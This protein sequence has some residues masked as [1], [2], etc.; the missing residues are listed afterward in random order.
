MD[1]KKI[2][3][4]ILTLFLL[5]SCW[6]EELEN[7][8]ILVSSE[9]CE[10]SYIIWESDK[11]SLKLKWVIV[12][13]EIKTIVS[14]MAWT[15]DFLDCEAW[16]KVSNDTLISKVSPDFNN[17]NII[18][19]TIQKWS[20]NNQKSN[21]KAVQT[22]TV[23]SFDIQISSLDNQILSLK[24]QIVL[25]ENNAV[26][27]T[28]SSNL[29]KSD[30]EKQITTLQDS[31]VTLKSNLNLAKKG[32]IDALEKIDIT[33]NSLYTN[34]KTLSID[35]LL[36]IDEIF[37]ITYENRDLNDKYDDYLWTKDSI[38]KQE[39]ENEFKTLNLRLSNVNNLSDIEIS[40]FLWELVK[41][42]EKTRKSVKESI[43]NINLTQLQVDS[44]Y[45]IF[46]LYWN[47]LTEIKNSWDSL[48]N[49]KSSITTNYDTQILWLEGQ[50]KT[51]ETNLENMKVNKLGST[52]VSLD[53]QL[54]SLD[55]QIKTLNTNLNS[56]LSQKSNLEATK[57]T[58]VL[59]L[60]NQILQINQ[61]IDSLNTNL[62]SRNIYA[63]ISWT[64]KQKMGS[65][66]N[67]IWINT[68]LCQI[69]P[70]D[71][72]TKIKIYS[73]QELDS[74]DKLVFEFN[75]IIHDV[76][77]ENVLVYK[78]SSTQNY[79]Y[80]SNYLDQD[81]FKEWEI[82]SLSFENK[83]NSGSLIQ[84]NWLDKIQDIKI[85]VSY[86][87]NKIDWNF[88]KAQTESWIL[89]KEVNLWIINGDFIDISSWLEWVSEVCR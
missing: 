38:L 81:Y 39:I 48:D 78:D 3:I 52:D 19:L 6:E 66:W 77:I 85:P 76:T 58:Q 30:I 17:P 41:L 7:N 64:I 61:S 45:N 84:E 80:E 54:S 9:S 20:L 88:V 50:I 35:N 18:N 4:L 71:K 69:I 67:N 24:E 56:L 55:G 87:K 65:I 23:S 46:L 86:I 33:R 70:D 75:G 51:S 1:K 8:D 73:P 57:R 72:S 79:I 29:N 26:L 22:S 68:P 36:K 42:N 12:S 37:W 11:T 60:D 34:I 27:T 53:L 16:K 10:W 83:F 2:I 31:L 62:S 5:T 74:W 13:D 28:K 49:S 63:N 44:F 14:P 15:I 25:L 32:K 21:L 47:N 43:I 59:N 89:E 40:I 82:L